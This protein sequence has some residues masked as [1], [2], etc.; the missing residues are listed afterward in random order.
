ELDTAPADTF[1]MPEKVSLTVKL[2]LSCVD[3]DALKGTKDANCNSDPCIKVVT[4]TVANP[5][6]PNDWYPYEITMGADKVA[7]AVFETKPNTQIQYKFSVNGVYEVLNKDMKDVW[8]NGVYINRKFDMG[9]KTVQGPTV[10]FMQDVD[11][12]K[13]SNDQKGAYQKTKES[14]YVPLSDPVVP[15]HFEV[16]QCSDSGQSVPEHVVVKSVVKGQMDKIVAKLTKTSANS[17]YF[18]TWYATANGSEGSNYRL[19]TGAAD[20]TGNIVYTDEK[21]PTNCLGKAASY[22]QVFAVNERVVR[23]GLNQCST[24]E[25]DD[26]ASQFETRIYVDMSCPNAFYNNQVV[27]KFSAATS[28]VYAFVAGNQYNCSTFI[29]D[30]EGDYSNGQYSYR[31]KAKFNTAVGVNSVTYYVSYG[32]KGN[33]NGGSE[34]QVTYCYSK[35]QSTCAAGLCPSA[36]KLPC[37][38]CGDFTETGVRPVVVEAGVIKVLRAAHSQCGPCPLVF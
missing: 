30:D 34:Q 5:N 2:D 26:S 13:L 38:A 25:P 32:P 16:T 4:N 8:V 23:V 19:A 11:C 20:K 15:I 12:S 17:R 21:L 29:P 33:E 18:G 7:V 37:K 22:R 24:C 1:V 9:V 27:G 31:C 28:S 6:N 35:G 14:H 36:A 10:A 3:L